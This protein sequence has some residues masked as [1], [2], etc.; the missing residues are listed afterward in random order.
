MRQDAELE[1]ADADRIEGAHAGHRLDPRTIVGVDE[2]FFGRHPVEPA[3][4]QDAEEAAALLL[5]ERR[6]VIRTGEVGENPREPQVLRVRDPPHEGRGL[7]MPH[8]EPSHARVDLQVH[9]NR[10]SCRPACLLE[11]RDLVQRGDRGGDVVF[12]DKPVLVRQKR[13]QE[14]DGPSRSQFPQQ[15]RLRDVRDREEVRP[16]VHQAAGDLL[17]AVAVGVGLDDGDI[18]D[19]RRQGGADVA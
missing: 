5:G 2:E 17:Q 11:P 13:A 12:A 1:E 18:A 9:R 8:A 4:G 14:Q 3:L 10:A 15:R 7:L 6:V 19:V 16:G